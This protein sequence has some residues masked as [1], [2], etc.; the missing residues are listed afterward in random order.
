[1]KLGRKAQACALLAL[2]CMQAVVA[3]PIPQNFL[4]GIDCKGIC[5]RQATAAVLGKA[6]IS[7]PD[8]YTL[9]Q[10]KLGLPHCVRRINMDCPKGTFLNEASGTCCPPE[11][12]CFPSL[13]GVCPHGTIVR[14]NCSSSVRIGKNGLPTPQGQ[15]VSVVT[16]NQVNDMAVSKMLMDQA[17]KK[18]ESG[19]K[20]PEVK[21]AAAKH[22]V[23][24]AAPAH[25]ASA[26]AAPA[27]DV[28]EP[29]D[30]ATH[31][32]K[33]K[34]LETLANPAV[35]VNA[36]RFQPLIVLPKPPVSFNVPD[37]AEV[38]IPEPV[39]FPRPQG[40]LVILPKPPLEFIPP[41]IDITVP[42]VHIPQRD[43]IVPVLPVPPVSFFEPKLDLDVGGLNL[44][45]KIAVI[46][47]SRLG[48]RTA[49]E[50]N[51]PPIRIPV[52]DP[53]QVEV[54]PPGQTIVDLTPFGSEDNTVVQ[55]PDWKINLPDPVEVIPEPGKV[56]VV[57]FGAA[58]TGPVY[59]F[60]LG[61]LPQ[62]NKIDITLPKVNFTGVTLPGNRNKD[63]VIVN[64]KEPDMPPNH[65]I[66][67]TVDES[68]AGLN[69]FPLPVK[70]NGL[71]PNTTNVNLVSLP[72]IA[73]PDLGTI[74]TVDAR[75]NSTAPRIDLQMPDLEV[76]RV[77]LPD[78]P[79]LG[80]DVKIVMP[81][82][83]LNRYVPAGIFPGDDGGLNLT[84]TVIDAKLPSFNVIPAL[85]KPLI[86]PGGFAI[87]TKGNGAGK[88]AWG[89]Q[90]SVEDQ[91]TGGSPLSPIQIG[92]PLP[93]DSAIGIVRDAIV[94]ALDPTSGQYCNNRCCPACKPD[95][96]SVV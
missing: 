59:E 6:D 96:K 11:D 62:R 16:A 87:G 43:F 52:P 21:A 19:A 95:R 53:V 85:N 44:Q 39:R 93:P 60:A 72:P 86:K 75:H 1:M 41:N 22:A 36:E 28:K 55:L 81:G 88:G 70:V 24:K 45:R 91:M 14:T 82:I 3:S 92:G 56:H 65:R 2:I 27:H 25:A 63:L 40:P 35:T 71:I 89:V 20:Q 9:E 10:D 4:K 58:Q 33:L 42:D 83:D 69:N 79:K 23:P 13:A 46:D 12:L 26:H 38:T 7:C 34:L 50:V 68:R 78:P 54:I 17:L 80:R 8:G 48:S 66:K 76:V 67:V 18:P 47:A 84:T 49:F 61:G 64:V 73:I 15:T 57:N 77:Q 51:V 94:A 30:A 90:V 29:A 31:G 74:V 37:Y 32:R 5:K